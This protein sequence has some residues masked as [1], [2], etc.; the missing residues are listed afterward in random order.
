MSR[1]KKILEKLKGSPEH[2]WL[3]KQMDNLLKGDIQYDEY[4]VT[5]MFINVEI[6]VEYY[7]SP[8]QKKKVDRVF[9]NIIKK[10]SNTHEIEFNDVAY[11]QK[12]LTLKI[13]QG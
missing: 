10:F 8:D 5:D 13:I 7:Q 11:D 1:A 2:K 4:G 6:P 9:N 3:T 12:V